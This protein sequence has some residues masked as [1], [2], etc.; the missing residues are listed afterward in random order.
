MPSTTSIF[1]KNAIARYHE[2]HVSNKNGFIGEVESISYAA[3]PNETSIDFVDASNIEGK[4]LYTTGTPGLAVIVVGQDP[5]DAGK[6]FNVKSFV[7]DTIKVAG[8]QT[9]LLAA[10]DK[11]AVVPPMASR[12]S[13]NGGHTIQVGRTKNEDL[14]LGDSVLTHNTALQIDPRGNVP[15][16]MCRDSEAFGRLLLL[17]I[18][19]YKKSGIGIHT[20]RPPQ[21]DDGTFGVA[22]DGAFY[23]KDGND[24]VS[25]A[26]LGIFATQLDLNFPNLAVAT[27]SLQVMGTHAIRQVGGTGKTFPAGANNWNRGSDIERDSG[28]RHTYN[29]VFVQFG[30]AFGDPLSSD[31][32]RFVLEA[33][34]QITRTASDDYPLGS[35]D[36]IVPVEDS[37]GIMVTGRRI[38]EDDTIYRDF[39]GTDQPTPDEQ[40]ET[41]LL[42]KAVA[43]GDPS[44]TLTID[45]PNGMWTVSD[46]QRQRGRFV[47]QFTFRGIQAVLNGAYDTDAPLYEVEADLDQDVDLLAEL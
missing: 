8:D 2:L 1:S 34:V 45:I 46:I 29:G 23:S 4:T 16:Y 27:G 13:T 5:S 37:F 38:L 31:Q 25:Q 9:L 33:N 30:G 12:V 6:C 21:L 10:G 14:G 35:Q 47:E 39:F 3:G 44:R 41:R 32:D 43:P 42:L 7:G 15:F 19:G 36:R 24:I 26:F 11:V 40:A 20:Y 22:P 18:G 28:N 17:G